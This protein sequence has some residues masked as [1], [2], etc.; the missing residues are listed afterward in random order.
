MIHL[1]ENVGVKSKSYPFTANSK[2]ELISHLVIELEQDRVKLPNHPDLLREMKYY[3]FERKGQNV[4]L[5]APEN[6]TGMYDDL[7]TA[8]ALA[9]WQ[10]DIGKRR[11]IVS[12]GSMT[13][14]RDLHG[15]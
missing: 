2:D 4:K 1:L 12:P 10:A 8:L 14:T 6:V 3:R 5:G 13:R 7:V 15:L 9:V 11:L